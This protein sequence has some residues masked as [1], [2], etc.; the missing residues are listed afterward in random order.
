MPAEEL[1]LVIPTPIFQAIGVFQG[2]CR[3]VE[4]YAPAL[5]DPAH[6]SFL[7]RS[8]AEHDPS[9]KQL[10]PY[11]ILK[12]RDQ[13]FHYTRGQ[14]AGE[15]RLRALR[16]VGI[17]GHI[18]PHDQDTASHPYRQGM[19]RELAEE[20]VIDTRYSETC[21][22]FINDDATPVGQVH[23]GVV[24]VF[25]L[26][27]PAVSPRE[28]NLTDAGFAPLG[29]LVLAK[30][31]FETWSQ[32]VLEELCAGVRSQE[33]GVRNQGSGVSGQGSDAAG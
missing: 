29:E 25:E 11:V 16:S 28:A 12:F 31:A 26:E 2:L 14:G 33:S 32:F 13:L 4:R 8:R 23:L 9:F 3:D 30:D 6:F 7:P 5:L 1:V 17:G 22:G 15:K 19:L 18:N 21:I 24:H 20:V 27:R 10:I